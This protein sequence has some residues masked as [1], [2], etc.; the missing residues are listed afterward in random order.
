M[1]YYV[2]VNVQNVFWVDAAITPMVTIPIDKFRNGSLDNDYGR[3][4]V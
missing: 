4:E 1:I 3:D 2:Q